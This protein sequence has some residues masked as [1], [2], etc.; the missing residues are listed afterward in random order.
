[1]NDELCIERVLSI[2]LDD[3]HSMLDPTTCAVARLGALIALDAPPE[4]DQ[5]DTARALASGVTLD[6]IVGV[7]TPSVRALA[8][9]TARGRLPFSSLR[10]PEPMLVDGID[11]DG[12]VLWGL[13]L[14]LLDDIVPRL[15]AGEWEI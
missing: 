3:D 4:T 5:W 11:V 6:E 2:G 15:L 12:H 14:R 9:P 7:L 1:M 13:T 8:D 10:F